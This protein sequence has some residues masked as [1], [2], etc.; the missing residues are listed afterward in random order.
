[1]MNII[2]GLTQLPLSLTRADTCTAS[3]FTCE[4]DST[5][6][7]WIAEP[8]INATGVGNATLSSN[9]GALT[10]T[11]GSSITLDLNPGTTLISTLTVLQSLGRDL[12]VICLETST[13]SAKVEIFTFRG[14]TCVNLM[15]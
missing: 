14:E 9:D 7:K 15:S 5:Q 2:A 13:D 3:V 6:I 11:R 12:T 1:M 4:T 10:D 8:I